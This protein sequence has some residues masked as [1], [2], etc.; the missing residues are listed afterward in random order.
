LASGQKKT[1]KRNEKTVFV[2]GRKRNIGVLVPKAL[3][4][5][6]QHKEWNGSLAPAYV[7]TSVQVALGQAEQGHETS[8]KE[9]MRN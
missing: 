8:K 5:G 6:L 7:P 9:R 1:P 4:V 3:V 2:S